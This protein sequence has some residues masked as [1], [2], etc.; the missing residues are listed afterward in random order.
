MYQH[1]YTDFFLVIAVSHVLYI[2]ESEKFHEKMRCEIVG[3]VHL[4]QNRAQL[5]ALVNAIMSHR[6]PLK[7]VSFLLP[8][9]RLLASQKG[10]FIVK[11]V[12]WRCG[13]NT[14]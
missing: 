12:V 4:V 5:W 13:G 8:A 2:R 1:L 7:G 10:H 14:F 9:E 3:W 6:V 11:L